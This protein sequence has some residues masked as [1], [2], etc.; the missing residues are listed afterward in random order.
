MKG[1]RWRFDAPPVCSAMS[2]NDTLDGF[3]QDL[4]TNVLDLRMRL[5]TVKGIVC[6]FDRTCRMI[7]H[8]PWLLGY[9]K[10]E[11]LKL[12]NDLE[13]TGLAYEEN[14]IA[15]NSLVN[16]M[17]KARSPD[18]KYPLTMTDAQIYLSALVLLESVRCYK[19]SSELVQQ[20]R[21]LV[22]NHI[23]LEQ[24]DDFRRKDAYAFVFETDFEFSR[25][26]Q[27]AAIMAKY[28]GEGVIATQTKTH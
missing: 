21:L 2:A 11:L 12:H 9:T 4:Q 27:K 3:D 18:L 1:H 24:Y 8:A 19:R 17:L 23:T 6:V 16:M 10:R 25:S 14:K 20:L 26:V 28:K 15:F 5:R 7:S 22:N 13:K